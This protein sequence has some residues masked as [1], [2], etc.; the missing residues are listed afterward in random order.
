MKIIDGAGMVMGRLASYAAKEALKGEEIVIL[1]CE[2]VIISGNR[3]M[4]LE[5][6][7]AR[8]RMAGSGFK[9]PI[10]RSPSYMIV[11]RAIRGMGPQYRTGRGRDAFKKIKCYNDTPKEFEN[12]KKIK[13]DIRKPLK[14]SV[15]KEFSK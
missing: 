13:L 7:Q 4:N 3:Q 15:V 5:H 14:H 1:N 12:A 9:G 8:R 10:H 11:K 6:F 2:Q